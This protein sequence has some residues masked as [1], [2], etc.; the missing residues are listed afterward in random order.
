MNRDGSGPALPKV[1]GT[2]AGTST[3]E[4]ARAISS[5]FPNRNRSARTRHARLRHL[6]GGRAAAQVSF[7]VPSAGQSPITRVVPFTAWPAPSAAW[8]E[9]ITGAGAIPGRY[10]SAAGV[11][12]EAPG[13]RPRVRDGE[14]AVAVVSVLELPGDLQAGRLDPL[15]KAFGVRGDGVEPVRPR[16]L[17]SADD[18][19]AAAVRPAQLDLGIA[20][21][22]S[23]VGSK[24][25]TA[26]RKSI[27]ACG[28]G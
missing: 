1:C 16:A 24:P 7:C 3:V 21:G 23:A 2:P 20:A 17:P 6:R 9:M 22:L 10:P 25:K 4:P 15:V 8:G 19:A 26:T 13:D 28:S 11:G 14:G 27:A 5:R 12:P 18:D